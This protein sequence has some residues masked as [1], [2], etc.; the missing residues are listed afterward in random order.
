MIISIG[1]EKTFDKVQQFMRKTFNK[2]GLEE[3]YLN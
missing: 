1:A 3:T 2:V